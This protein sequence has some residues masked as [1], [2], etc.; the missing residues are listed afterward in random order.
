MFA[1]VQK[2]V[3]DLQDLAKQRITTVCPSKLMTLATGLA[4][5]SSYKHLST[6]MII[7]Y[8]PP[9]PPAACVNNGPV[10]RKWTDPQI[11]TRSCPF[12]DDVSHREGLLW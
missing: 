6:V 5:F 11:K 7:H 12:D 3:V 8:M 9:M 2:R 10:H 1:L 4:L